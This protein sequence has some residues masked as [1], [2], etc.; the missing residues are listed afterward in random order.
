EI[1]GAL[2]IH[3]R[4]LTISAARQLHCQYE[5][6]QSE[7][8]RRLRS[9]EQIS[10]GRHRPHREG[11]S[12]IHHLSQRRSSTGGP[13]TLHQSTA[14]GGG[15]DLQA[16]RLPG[17]GPAQVGM[18]LAASIC[19]SATILAVLTL[20]GCAGK[21]QARVAT[22]PPPPATKPSATAIPEPSPSANKR[23]ESTSPSEQRTQEKV[24]ES[25]SAI[26]VPEAIIPL[27]TETGKASW[28]GPPYHNRRGSNGEIYDMHALTAA[29]RTLPLGS[30]VRVTNLKTGHS[31]TVRITDRGP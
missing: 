3:K 31:T 6:L 27:A 22:P 28:Y 2:G 29:H 12:G 4:W 21:K 11:D 17:R 18:K 7:G 13:T 10:R 8:G 20:G 14:C 24:R 15:E 19:V 30:T 16:G 23:P 9:R 26:P 5:A 25:T 1:M